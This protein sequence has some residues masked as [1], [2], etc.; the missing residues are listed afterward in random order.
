[1]LQAAT[2]RVRGKVET[3]GG[4]LISEEEM[5]KRISAVAESESG[6]YKFEEIS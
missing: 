4:F 1:M 5:S 6:D 3:S 2:D